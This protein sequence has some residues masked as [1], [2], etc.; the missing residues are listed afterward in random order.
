MP[1]N[2]IIFEYNLEDG[3]WGFEERR[4]NAVNYYH[5]NKCDFETDC[6]SIKFFGLSLNK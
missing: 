4:Q 5:I 1:K 6:N 2:K 3:G